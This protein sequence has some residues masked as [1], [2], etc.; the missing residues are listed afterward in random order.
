MTVS[1]IDR[2]ALMRN[3]H[4]IARQARPHMPSYRAAFR[5]GLKAAWGLVATRREF[6]AVS[7]RVK[8]RTY[9]TAEIERSRVATR[10]VGASY[11][12]F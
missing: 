2:S 12:P 4:R 6:A 10:R 8:P 11:M 9:S 7:A 3:A 5:Y 1:A